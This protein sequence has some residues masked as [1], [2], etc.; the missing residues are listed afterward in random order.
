MKDTGAIDVSMTNRIQEIKDRISGEEDTIENIDNSIKENGK[1][2]TILNQNIQ[3]I[4]DTMRRPNLRIS[5]IDRKEDFQLKGQKYLQQIYR[6]KLPQPKEKDAHE[7]SR[8]LQKS[9]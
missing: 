1:C 4:Q 8:S 7:H 2:K 3:E 6:R 5:G 9:K